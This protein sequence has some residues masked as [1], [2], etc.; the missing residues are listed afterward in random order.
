MPP[1]RLASSFTAYGR[2]TSK[3]TTCLGEFPWVKFE[4]D[5]PGIVIRIAG[6]ELKIPWVS[7]TPE[8]RP[9]KVPAGDA[10]LGILHIPY[11]VQAV[12]D[13]AL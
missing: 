1:P 2:D 13:F 9:K 7:W 8:T 12:C 10:R 11:T 5:N 3:L 6:Y 4:Y